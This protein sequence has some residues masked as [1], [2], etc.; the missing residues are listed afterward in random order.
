MKKYSSFRSDL[1]DY[2][3]LYHEKFVPFFRQL[4]TQLNDRHFV[5]RP[6]PLNKSSYW[7]S[8]FSDISN[9]HINYHLPIE[10]WLLAAKYVLT[11]GCTSGI[12][13]ILASKPSISLDIQV[14][15]SNLPSSIYSL[16]QYHAST[17]SSLVDLLS[18][19][20]SRQHPNSVSALVSIDG[21]A[22]DKLVSLIQSAASSVN[23]PPCSVFSIPRLS[24][25]PL[26]KSLDRSSVSFWKW[27]TTPTSRVQRLIS[28]MNLHF[29]SSVNFN[30]IGFNSFSFF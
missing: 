26:D 22:T 2:N 18:S 13:A 21:R 17:L 30:R 19:D 4:T 25:S 12:Q 8:Q 27:Q 23:L 1:H 29:S 28:S 9:I 11:D 6:H 5:F 15:P 14:R 16:S 10:P 3:R 24:L 20:I 7:S